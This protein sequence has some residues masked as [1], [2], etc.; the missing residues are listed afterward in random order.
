MAGGK[1]TKGQRAQ[2]A[3]DQPDL[4]ERP[5]GVWFGYASDYEFRQA[6]NDAIDASGMS[7]EEIADAMERMLGS[8][9]DFP[10]SK[11]NLNTWTAPSRTDWRMPAVYV[12]AFIQVTGAHH[13]IR[14]AAHA[15]GFS[16]QGH[17]DKIAAHYGRLAAER[18]RIEAE[19]RVLDRAMKAKR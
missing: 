4:F 14:R 19:M 16:V 5:A 9:P 1:I 10:V 17:D 7:R 13:I 2:S 15:V 6:L 11:V 8:H 18:K 3:A 12:L